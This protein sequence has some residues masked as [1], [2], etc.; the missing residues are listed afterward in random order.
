MR[1]SMENTNTGLRTWMAITG[2]SRGTRRI[3]ARKSGGS[4][5]AVGR[6]G[7]LAGDPDGS[8]AFLPNRSPRMALSPDTFG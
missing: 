2:C 7:S 1:R 8:P 6:R 4:G 3:A 5:E